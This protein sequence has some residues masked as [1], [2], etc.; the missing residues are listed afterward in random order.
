MDILNERYLIR[1]ST[2]FDYYEIKPDLGTD[3]NDTHTYYIVSETIGRWDIP[4]LSYI[5]VE[6][7]LV[8]DDGTVYIRNPVGDI[9]K[10]F[11]SRCIYYK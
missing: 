1:N 8:K 5:D 9:S 2:R 4:C 6:G 7:Q 11:I 3:L 10:R